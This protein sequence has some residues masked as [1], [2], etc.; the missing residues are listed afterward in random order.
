MRLAGVRPHP[1]RAKQL[2]RLQRKERNKQQKI[3]AAREFRKY[4]TPS[5][6][7]AIPEEPGAQEIGNTYSQYVLQ[8]P[9]AQ[10]ARAQSPLLWCIMVVDTSVSSASL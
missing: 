10:P 9:P 5:F 2:P 3:Q 7:N 8:T 4:S 6:L 1:Y